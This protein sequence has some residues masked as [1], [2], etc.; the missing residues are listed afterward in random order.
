MAAG[1]LTR[2]PAQEERDLVAER[3][4]RARRCPARRLAGLRSGRAVL[5]D[6][7]GRRA[8]RDDRRRAAA[9]ASEQHP[10]LG[11]HRLRRRARAAR[12]AATT[13]EAQPP[14]P[15]PGRAVMGALLYHHSPQPCQGSN[16]VAPGASAAYASPTRKSDPVTSTASSGERRAR[17]RV[18]PPRAGRARRAPARSPTAAATMPAG[19]EP[20]PAHARDD[21]L[22]PRAAAGARASPATPCRP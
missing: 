10:H 20:A 6:G 11:R 15:A 22:A 14:P 17:A 7:L 9:P 13:T 1:R 16:S 8:H 21:H 12:R 5:D 3:L 4:A 18:A 2:E 19:I